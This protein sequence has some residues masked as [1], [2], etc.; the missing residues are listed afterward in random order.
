[1]S[2]NIDELLI[3]RGG[4][5]VPASA[6]AG[7]IATSDVNGNISWVTVASL[8]GSSSTTF[9]AGND[10]RLSDARTP[11]AHASTHGVA[12]S[13]RVRPSDLREY[14]DLRRIAAAATMPVALAA[15]SAGVQF[16]TGNTYAGW[17]K[18]ADAGTYG[19]LLIHTGS[20]APAGITA[21][22]ASVWDGSN[23]LI[24]STADLSGTVVAANTLYKVPLSASVT[25]TLDEELY[26]GISVVGTTLFLIGL[27]GRSP[28][29]WSQP[30][31]ATGGQ[32][33]KVL[34]KGGAATYVSGSVP[35]LTGTT[36]NMPWVALVA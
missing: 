18:A 31:L 6:A 21:L 15:T 23:S 4:L 36:G 2:R 27:A 25:T 7:K 19:N 17:C 33:A 35:A 29:L 24:T 5:Q 26:L 9:A 11:T 12:G 22:Q 28:S 30:G 32:G 8:Q 16:T 20:T 1:M 10:A 34:C 13:D 14:F 3:A